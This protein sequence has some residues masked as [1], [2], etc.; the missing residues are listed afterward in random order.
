ML[1][2]ETVAVYC[3]N[4]MEHADTVR[5]SQETHYVSTTETNRLMLFGE[6]VAAEYEQLELSLLMIFLV[7]FLPLPIF[8]PQI[9]LPSLTP[10][11]PLAVSLIKKLVWNPPHLTLPSVLQQGRSLVSYLAAG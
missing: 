3:E 11:S 5:T 9:F 10:Y 4:H 1:F 2:G 8:N 7:Q 6:T